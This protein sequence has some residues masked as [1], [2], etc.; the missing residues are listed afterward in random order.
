ML[1]QEMFKTTDPRF[2]AT[3]LITKTQ[4]KEIYKNHQFSF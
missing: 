4:S 1:F 2:L 3:T